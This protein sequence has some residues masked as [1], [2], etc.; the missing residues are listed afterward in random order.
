M[1]ESGLRDAAHL[2]S[3]LHMM[4][5]KRHRRSSRLISAIAVSA[6]SACFSATFIPA[7]VKA[8]EPVWSTAP[9]NYV[10]VDQDLRTV[11][12]QFGAN[13]GLR[14]VLSDAVQGK[15]HGRLPSA[16]PREFLSNLAQM[17][18]LDWYYDGSVL[19]IS[20][21]TEAQTHLL[22]L[23]GLTFEALRNGLS[24]TGL[25]DPRFD[26][27]PGLGKAVA[28][29]SGPPHYWAMVQQAAAALQTA[30]GP[31][32]PPEQA[33]AAVALPAPKA[34]PKKPEVVVF[35]GSTM[36]REPLP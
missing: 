17:F 10:V 16:P 24:A 12:Q 3:A 33:K 29:V 34:V 30:S 36:T 14:I 8:A 9:Y 32:P 28:L 6:L 20:S 4:L 26:L 2:C 5:M 15:V 23:Q 18:G 27:K 11:L 31:P 13:I 22:P 35:R 19:S 7:K 21:T 25:L 1:P